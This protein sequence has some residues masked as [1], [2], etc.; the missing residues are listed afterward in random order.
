MLSVIVPV[1]RVE[2]YLPQCLESLRAQTVQ[3]AEFLL[4]DDGSPDRCGEICEEYAA[5]DSRFR[6]FHK[7]NGGL[8][9]ARNFGLARA[10]GEWILFV[11]SDDWIEPTLC[12]A[13][14]ACAQAQKADLVLFDYEAESPTSKRRLWD[15]P[16]PA[17]GPVSRE[18][19]MPYCLNRIWTAAWS[20]LYRRELFDGIRFPEGF[21]F[22]DVGCTY[23]LI[24]KAGRI[25]YLD[26][27]LYHYRARE[28]SITGSLDIRKLRDSFLMEM[29]RRK[30]LLAWGYEPERMREQIVR[31]ALMHCIHMPEAPGDP[32]WTTAVQTLRESDLVPAE[33]T[34]R[35]KGMLFLFRH[36]PGLFRLLCRLGKRKLF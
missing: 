21:F 15:R 22:E 1:Y 14:L 3:D 12:S 29:Q 33:L 20:M 7:E 18:T 13:V 6:V 27:C 24:W 23:K 32:A 9:S 26:R 17:P 2:A 11:D 19:V 16:L 25:C 5:L 4:I 8:S 34:R 35:Q 28:D 10:R 30:D 36:A 31:N